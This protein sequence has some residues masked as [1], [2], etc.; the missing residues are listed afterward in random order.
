MLEK[1]A[2]MKRFE[3]SPLCKE[4]KKQTSA[5]ENS[6]K[7]LTIFYKEKATFKKYN[8]SN[9]VYESQYSFYEYY[10]I[11]RFN[12]MSSESKY[13]ILLSFYNNLN[14][15]NNINPRKERTKEEK[16]AVHNNASELYNEYLG[17]YF[18]QCKTL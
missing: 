18:D 14:K 7:N 12:I 6:I 5:A 1:A 15:F 13:P 16:S 9:L 3:Y 10:N 11:H 8:R 4:L 17:L 2:T